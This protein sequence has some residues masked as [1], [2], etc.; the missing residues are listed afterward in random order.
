MEP[1]VR[2]T[3]EEGSVYYILQWSRLKKAD[4]Y[5]IVRKVPAEP[6][7]FE[8]YFMDE[9]KKL[10]LFFV[11]RAWYGGLRNSIRQF[12]DPELEKEAKRR[13]VLDKYDCYYRYTVLHSFKDMTDIL[14]FFSRTYFPHKSDFQ[15]TGRFINIF[16]EEKTD[17]KITTI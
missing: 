16:V 6:G 5:E 8:L 17:D 1:T 3:I 13:A 7:L 4:K 15:S 10:N 9:K 11:A 2:R 12:T 14:F